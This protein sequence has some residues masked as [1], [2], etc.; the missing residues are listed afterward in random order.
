[1]VWENLGLEGAALLW[2][3]CLTNCFM[4]EFLLIYDMNRSDDSRDTVFLFL[5]FFFFF[6]WKVLKQVKC[7]L[8]GKSTINVGRLR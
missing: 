1:M 5:S 7:L 4:S 3:V 2:P 6:R 8:K